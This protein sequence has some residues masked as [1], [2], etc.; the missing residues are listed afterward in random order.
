MMRRRKAH[1]C[2]PR[3]LLVLATSLALGVAPGEAWAEG[4]TERASTDYNEVHEIVLKSGGVLRGT[5]IERSDASVRLKIGQDN[6][7]VLPWSVIASITNVST[8]ESAS[9]AR[10]ASSAPS[11]AAPDEREAPER[12][13]PSVPEGDA[14]ALVVHRAEGKLET[15]R[16]EPGLGPYETVP[17]DFSITI[18][19]TS[20]LTTTG[21]LIGGTLLLND[22]QYNDQWSTNANRG[23]TYAL[24]SSAGMLAGA[25]AAYGMGAAYNLDGRFGETL[26]LGAALGSVGLGLST[27]ALVRQSESFPSRLPLWTMTPILVG[28]AATWGYVRS[29]KKRHG[30]PP[31]FLGSMQLQLM[32]TQGG[33]YAGA[34]ARF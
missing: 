18:A 1:I 16:V 20:V 22:V 11:T 14:D 25:G 8:M 4:P 3:F 29:H 13:E 30:N 32:P 31:R 33:A 24:V 7:A 27:W 28:T 15:R 17:R 34:T 23:I 19:V 2:S 6:I 12:E 21:V 26:A 10:T 5:I 9:A